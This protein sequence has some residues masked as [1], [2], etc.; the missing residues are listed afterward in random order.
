MTEDKRKEMELLGGVAQLFMRLGIKS[1]TM[2]EIARQLGISK[3]TLYKYAT[4]KKQLVTKAMQI[5]IEQEECVLL[6]MESTEGNAIDKSLATNKMVSEK[7]QSIQPAVIFD[8]QKYYPEAWA[9]MEDHK[10]VF[11]HNQVKENLIEGI[12]EGLYRDN[13]NPDLVARIYVTLIDSIFDSSLYR[14]SNNSFLE[15]HTE[16]VRYHLRGITNA[17]GVEYMQQLFN[18]KNSDII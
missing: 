12:N 10:C 16:V 9:I 5:V 17:K 13:L 6:E 3:K 15:M 2:D 8:M 7:L 4:D 1:L 18:N 11:I 14:D